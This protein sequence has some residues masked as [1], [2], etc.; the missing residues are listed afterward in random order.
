M[1]K[2]LGILVVG[3][4]IIMGLSAGIAIGEEIEQ[5]IQQLSP[6]IQVLSNEKFEIEAKYSYIRS[7]P[8]G[9]GIFIIVMTAKK[10][11]SGYVSLKINADPVLNAELDKKNLDKQSP[12]AELTIQPTEFTELKT[13]KIVITATYHK[14]TKHVTFFNWINRFKFPLSPQNIGRLLNRF[15]AKSKDICFIDT[16]LIILDV[17]MFDWTSD[18]LPDAIIKRD[19]L[20]DWLEVE[21]PE[22][23][24]FTGENCY[25]YIT[26][27]AHLVVEHWTFLYEN[28]EMRICYHV[29]IPPYNWSKL[30]LR[31]RG[32]VNSIFAA[33]RESDG[34]VYE[35]SVGDYPIFYG[36]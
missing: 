25:A 10:D 13:Y 29:M 31:E 8:G 2:I 20:I 6:D 36:Y 9:G 27:P 32:E 21:H 26:Y 15:N 5:K 35:I 33:R 7:Y 34:T 30:C 24:T 17:E 28:W 23:G 11:F 19:E 16:K 4:L 12:V 22:F 18:N 1:K 14:K 3:V